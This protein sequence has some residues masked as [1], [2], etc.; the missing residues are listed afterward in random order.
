MD[1][2]ILLTLIDKFNGGPVGIDSLSAAVGEEKTT[3]EDVYEPFLIKEGYIQ[4]T[5]RGR[6]ATR[7]AYEHF[8]RMWENSK[9]KELF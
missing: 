6:I 4:R 5:N 8:G 9:Q 1:R 2:T 7:H 3:I